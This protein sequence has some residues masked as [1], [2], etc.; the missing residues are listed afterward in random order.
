MPLRAI[1]AGDGGVRCTGARMKILIWDLD[2]T[3]ASRD[4]MWAG[5]LVSVANRCLPARSV[6]KDD[7]RP[8]LQSGFPWHTPEHPHPNQNANEWWAALRPVFV[9]AYEGV[10]IEAEVAGDLAKEVRSAFLDA[11]RWR[12]LDD[13]MPCL[14]ALGR[15]GWTHSIL[16]NHVPELGDLVETLG[17]SPFFAQVVTSAQTGYEKPHTE[18]FEGLLRQCPEGTTVWM[19]G[20]SLMA[21]VQ[22]AERVGIPGILVRK[23]QDG[24]RFYCDSLAETEEVISTQEVPP[25]PR[26]DHAVVEGKCRI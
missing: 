6:T 1:P 22:G 20:D 11:S 21:D 16:S 14:S 2:G 7:I 9:R 12:V 3:L 5:T 8:F 24:S 25:T 15:L 13:V 17:L 26:R 4:G 10:G 19:I 23:K 18:A